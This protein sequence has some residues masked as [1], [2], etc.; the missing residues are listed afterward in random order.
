MPIANLLVPSAQIPQSD[1]SW[2]GDVFGS[3]GKGI[4]QHKE[5]KSFNKLADLIAEGQTTAPFAPTSPAPITSTASSYAAAPVGPVSRGPAQGSTYQPFIETVKGRINNPYGLAAVAATGRAESGWSPEKANATWA[6]PSVSGQP[7]TSGGILSWRGPRL[8]ALQTFAAQKGE[9][10]GSISPQ[11]QAEFFLNED[12]GLIERLNQAKS[13]QEAADTMANAWRFAGY[14]Q[15]GGEAARRRALTQNYYAQEFGKGNPAAAAIE[16]AA[17]RSGYV[18]PMVSAPNSRPQG[19]DAG[20]FGGGAQVAQGREGLSDAMGTLRPFGPSE[21]R[22]NPDGSY[23]TE[24]ST[25]WQLPD[26]SWANVPSLWMGPSGPKQFNPDDE[27]GIMGAMRKY[28]AQT[29]QPFPRFGS[30]QEAVSAAQARSG[31]GGSGAPPAAAFAPQPSQQPQ[32]QPQQPQEQSNLLAA[33]VTPIQRGGADPKL[34][35]LMLRDKNLRQAG[36]QLW[37]QNATGKTSEPW[38][39]VNLPDGTLARANQVTGAIEKVGNFAKPDNDTAV[40]GNDLVRKSDGTVIYNGTAKAPQIVELFDE[41]T[42]QPYKA[43]YNPQT[44]SYDRVG[45]VKAR[46][47]MSL[48][49]NPDGTVTLTEGTVGNMPKLTESEGR[50]TGFYGR[51][52]ESHK[53]LNT[54]EGEG[55][56]V[57]NKV[58]DAVPVVGNFAKSDDAQK[59]TQAKRDFIN[60]VLRRESGA[61]ISPEEFSNADQQYFPQPGDGEEVI[62]QKRRNRETTIQGLKV[63]SGQGAAFAVPPTSPSTQA[64]SGAPKAG[65]V[66]DGYRFKGGDPADPKNWEKV[67]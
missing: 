47:G 54:L 7:G 45:G 33:G 58:A 1:F 18:D 61:V 2:I 48:T 50:N 66:E 41:A 59:Y 5:N 52:I 27:E 56:S 19:F 11:T 38:Q 49:T 21:R 64:P 15:Q 10:L 17:P 16:Q 20:R 25:T 29:G 62:K 67:K 9:R 44:R 63:S 12:P 53:T 40:V 23:S 28:E 4:E 30:E 60:A 37:Q 35:Q 57:I 36:L 51:G 65:I 32:M 22:S 43:Q 13:P 3:I 46:S 24:V 42:G 6:D 26:G 55:T 34:I 14:D 31:A 8:Q 39:F